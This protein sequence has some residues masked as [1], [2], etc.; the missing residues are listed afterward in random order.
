MCL[1]KT[2]KCLQKNNKNWTHTCTCLGSYIRKNNN[3]W[4]FEINSC[5]SEFIWLNVPLIS[6]LIYRLTYLNRKPLKAFATTNS[7]NYQIRLNSIIFLILYLLFISN[8]ES[9]R[10]VV[11][12]NSID[13]H[14]S[15]DLG[16]FTVHSK[17]E[18]RLI[19][20]P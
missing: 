20:I 6:R 5:S 14:I 19:C 7:N 3:F 13:I 2:A 17:R 11:Q 10:K 15:I 16:W 18:Y 4:Q 1:Q 12:I 8:I 9:L